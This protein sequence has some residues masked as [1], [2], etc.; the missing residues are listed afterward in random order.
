MAS[1]SN[2]RP[3]ERSQDR[4]RSPH[5]SR[6]K[7][8]SPVDLNQQKS[9]ESLYNR[10]NKEALWRQRRQVAE[11][12]DY[13]QRRLSPARLSPYR[14]LSPNRKAPTSWAEFDEE[15]NDEYLERCE[16]AFSDLENYKNKFKRYTP[17]HNKEN[18]LPDGNEV[19]SSKNS[20]SGNGK[21]SNSRRS[22]PSPN[23]VPPKAIEIEQDMDVL[24]R[25]QKDID[26]GKNQEV[27]ADY[28]TKLDKKDRLDNQ[29][30][31]PDKYEK[32]TRRNWDKQVKIWRKQLHYWEDPKPISELLTPGT[33]PCP[34]PHRRKSPIRFFSND[35]KNNSDLDF[36][37]TAN[38]FK[39]QPIFQKAL[40]L[41][42]V[43][44]D[45]KTENL[46][47]SS[48]NKNTAMSEFDMDEN[49]VSH[50]SCDANDIVTLPAIFRK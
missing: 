47:E 40:F 34:S 2:K 46:P 21:Y 1:T 16:R 43:K 48:K 17:E 50:M 10:N 45:V 39:P 44:S 4:S 29:P 27:Y 49:S 18:Y 20:S 41:N 3:R 28:L 5:F 35:L 42:N 19:K 11:H 25:R 33:S 37:N 13:E 23:L 26:Y 22:T 32:M 24:I 8:V 6:T 9:P 7:S 30:W 38:V 14:S 12:E 15:D 36:E 31:T